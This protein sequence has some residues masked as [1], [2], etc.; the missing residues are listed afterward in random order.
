MVQQP[1]SHHTAQHSYTHDTMIHD[2]YMK[3]HKHPSYILAIAST[4]TQPARGPYIPQL[5]LYIYSY[6]NHHG[7]TSQ[8]HKYYTN[9]YI[10]HPNISRQ[11][12]KWLARILSTSR[13][14]SRQEREKSLVYIHT[15]THITNITFQYTIYHRR[16]RAS[17][18]VSDAIA[19]LHSI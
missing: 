1:M 15:Q 12:N 11:T 17:P 2:H 4:Y 19:W 6:S 7:T 13:K 14:W 10:K 3:S 9:Q 18:H 5:L 16:D 8:N